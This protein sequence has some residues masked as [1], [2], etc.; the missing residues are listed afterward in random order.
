MRVADEIELTGGNNGLLGLITFTIVVEI[1]NGLSCVGTNITRADCRATKVS[2][3]LGLLATVL[4]VRGLFWG[5]LFVVGARGSATVR[6]LVVR[7]TAVRNLAVIVEALIKIGALSGG[8]CDS[9]SNDKLHFVYFIRIKLL[10][11]SLYN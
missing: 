1:V 7:G 10:S 4:T 9:A 6:G 5:T 2:P 3:A 8:H 11:V